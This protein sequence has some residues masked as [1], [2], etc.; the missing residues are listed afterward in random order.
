MIIH[1]HQQES[2]LLVLIKR[3]HTLHIPVEKKK[4]ILKSYQDSYSDVEEEEDKCPPKQPSLR[5][6]MRNIFSYF[7]RRRAQNTPVPGG[8]K[9]TLFVKKLP[10]RRS[11][12][13]AL[14]ER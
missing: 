1:L 14:R 2:C 13:Y 11:A 6:S 10:P 9:R 7:S 8:T 4:A 12:S 5:S 3:R